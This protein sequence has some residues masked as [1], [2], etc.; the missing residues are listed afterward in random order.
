MGEEIII[1]LM[2]L[3]AHILPLKTGK[4]NYYFNSQKALRKILVVR[5]LHLQEFHE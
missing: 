4:R 1:G 3:K 5:Y 2:M